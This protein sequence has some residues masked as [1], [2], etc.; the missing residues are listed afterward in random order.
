MCGSRGQELLAY[1]TQSCV[2][3]DLLTVGRCQRDPNRWSMPLAA[4]MERLLETANQQRQ[5]QLDKLGLP[6]NEKLDDES[7][8]QMYNTWRS[9]P[10]SWM[11]TASYNEWQ[12][13]KESGKNQAAHQLA[14]RRFSTFLFQLSGSKF[15]LHQ[16]IQLPLVQQ[17]SATSGSVAQPAF[18]ILL[19]LI[20]AYEKHKTT[21]EYRAR[22]TRV[23]M[24]S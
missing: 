2:F 18:D 8:K 17:L 10:W 16:L 19:D 11:A 22:R 14:K 21:K 9:E 6:S 15:L 13:L 24:S 20:V 3:D 5:I 1:I 7:M 4:K 12:A 23:Y